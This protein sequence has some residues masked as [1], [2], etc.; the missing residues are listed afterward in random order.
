MDNVTIV[1]IRQFIDDLTDRLDRNVPGVFQDDQY[2]DGLKR[3]IDMV[4]HQVFQHDSGT[5]KMIPYVGVIMWS[6]QRIIGHLES[7]VDENIEASLHDAFIGIEFE[8]DLVL[9]EPQKEE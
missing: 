4:E 7:C 3:W 2:V 1:K 6:L 8:R 5:A 9:Q